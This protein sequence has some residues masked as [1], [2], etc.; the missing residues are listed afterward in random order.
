MSRESSRQRYGAIAKLAIPVSLANVTET[1]GF[2]IDSGML[3]RFGATSIAA[4]GVSGSL[5][6]FVALTAIA[7]GIGTQ[8]IIAREGKSAH[9]QAGFHAGTGLVAALSAGLLA[10]AVVFPSM[11]GMLRLLGAHGEL[12]ELSHAYLMIVWCGLPLTFM[13]SVFR[14]ILTAHKRASYITISSF[15]FLTIKVVVNLLVLPGQTTSLEAVKVLGGS[16]L[17]A[18]VT[19]TLFLITVLFCL[20]KTCPVALPPSF[21]R[22]LESLRLIFRISSSV[23]L[24]F[25][26]W[27]VG[28]L[29]ITRCLGNFAPIHLAIY[30]LAMRI[31]GLFLLAV[32]GFGASTITFVSSAFGAGEYSEMSRWRNRH[33][34][35]AMVL[36]FAGLACCLVFPLTLLGLF[37]PIVNA[38]AAMNV[39]M[40]MA[41]CGYLI[42]VRTVNIIGGSAIRTMG[43]PIYFLVA[44]IFSFIVIVALGGSLITS[45][46]MGVLG[47]FVAMV[48]DETVRAIVTLVYFEREVRVLNAPVLTSAKACSTAE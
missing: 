44:Q 25:G 22:G 34:K 46:A 23:F 20:R 36:S 2:L 29:V 21:R 5:M 16:M 38:E 30:H 37:I 43:K 17:L 48:I 47:A 28:T 39:R 18:S 6:M 31:Q 40:L 14:S 19:Q 3:R 42:C 27:Q 26:I 10:L 15:L 8:A 11:D 4:I 9:K 33:L 32:S 35:L 7:L 24:E 41:I 12:A 13:M 45:V 1:V